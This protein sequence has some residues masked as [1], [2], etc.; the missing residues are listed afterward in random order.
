MIKFKQIAS[1]LALF[2]L[3]ALI[4]G[5]APA[6]SC[7]ETILAAKV[8]YNMLSILVWVGFVGLVVWVLK[9]GRRGRL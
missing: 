7:K 2:G 4:A 8:G 5:T 3:Y 9:P 1:A 6:F